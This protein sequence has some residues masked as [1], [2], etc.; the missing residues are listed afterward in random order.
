MGA[1][2]NVMVMGTFRVEVFLELANTTVLSVVSATEARVP[3][4]VVVVNSTSRSFSVKVYVYF[5]PFFTGSDTSIQPGLPTSTIS[6]GHT[7]DT[8]A[9]LPVMR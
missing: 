9:L 1:S 2:F 5:V 7:N 4:A 3:A 8:S 6:S